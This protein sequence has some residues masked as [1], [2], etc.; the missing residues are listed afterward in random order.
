MG[1]PKRQ[2]VESWLRIFGF[3]EIAENMLG[4]YVVGSVAR[5]TPRP[6][7]D[8]DIAVIVPAATLTEDTLDLN[9][10][11]LNAMADEV[12]WEDRRVDIQVF[13]DQDPRLKSYS[14]IPLKA[15]SRARVEAEAEE[16]VAVQVQDDGKL[17]EE[18]VRAI[19]S[20]YERHALRADTFQD[21]QE[22][23]DRILIDLKLVE[24][25]RASVAG[26]LNEVRMAEG[27]VAL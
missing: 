8:L 4:A 19:E 23:L 22:L 5:K 27:Y 12:R 26:L 24:P 9:T 11:I 10:D 17:P 18:I 16:P 7:S 3:D 25:Y 2:D 14:K 6:D 21:F 1:Y 20:G 13:S 15:Y